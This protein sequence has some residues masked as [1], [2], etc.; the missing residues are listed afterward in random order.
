MDIG[1]V[2]YR[3]SGYR[4]SITIVSVFFCCFLSSCSSVKEPTPANL[5]PG[6]NVHP[7]GFTDNNSAEFHG[8]TIRTIDWDMTGCQECHGTDYSGG[9]ANISCSGSGCHIDSP[10]SCHTCHGDFND[11][12]KIAP[13]R[14][15]DKNTDPGS[16]GV[17]AHTAHLAGRILSLGY[18]CS[19]CHIVPNSVYEPR[20]VD[21]DLPAEVI[22]SGIAVTTGAKPI[23]NGDRLTCADSYCHG[24]WSLPKAESQSNFAYAED[25]MNGNNATPVWTDASTVECGSC[26]TGIVNSDGEIIDPGKHVDG[27]VNVFGQEYPMVGGSN[28]VGFNSRNNK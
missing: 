1:K 16:R 9:I 13:P 24:N 27:N 4:I 10:E 12:T 18:D 25:F 26:H 2:M 21:T 6:L 28:V 14:D 19:T 17:G 11:S 15:I 23:W 8:L 22:F 3:N 20:H 7:D 5:Q